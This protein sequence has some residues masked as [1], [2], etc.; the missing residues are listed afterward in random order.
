MRR[1]SLLCH[2]LS[3]L[4]LAGNAMQRQLG[5]SRELRRFAPFANSEKSEISKL[6][7]RHG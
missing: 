6:V 1:A 3:A 2:H 7:L 4:E 5:I